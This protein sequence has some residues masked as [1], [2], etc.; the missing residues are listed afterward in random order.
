MTGPGAAVDVVTESST[1][2][3]A[4]EVWVVV[5]AGGSVVGGELAGGKVVGG[6]VVGGDVEG[7]CVA[8]GTVGATTVA[9]AVVVGEE[10]AT[11]G[12]V[13]A[14][15]VPVGATVADGVAAGPAPS[16]PPSGTV[17]VTPDDEVGAAPS[18][19]DDVVETASAASAPGWA[20][21][22]GEIPPPRTARG[23]V[24]IAAATTGAN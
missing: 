13:V 4:C 17:V 9:A 5:G 20:A 19:I 12:R 15:V 22:N 24:S 2:S 10:V 11:R 18:G 16:V 7:G 1:A 23:A 6:S 14:G 8:G 3:V 21:S